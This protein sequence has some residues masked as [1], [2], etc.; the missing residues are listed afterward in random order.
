MIRKKEKK[1]KSKQNK[2]KLAFSLVEYNICAHYVYTNNIQP[3][4]E[5]RFGVCPLRDT[6]KIYS[7]RVQSVASDLC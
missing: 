6:R 1:I 5:K 4:R 7:M 2:T 3:K